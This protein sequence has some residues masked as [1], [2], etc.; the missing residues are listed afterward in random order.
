VQW[1]RLTAR[2]TDFRR[3]SNP[4]RGDRAEKVNVSDHLRLSTAGTFYNETLMAMAT[5]GCR[6]LYM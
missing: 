6:R 1:P 4:D 5:P 3:K 2:K